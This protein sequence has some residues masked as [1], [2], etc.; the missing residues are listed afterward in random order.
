MDPEGVGGAAALAPSDRLSDDR[1][2]TALL[3]D[4]SGA[5]GAGTAAAADAGG[6]A[7]TAAAY[8]TGGAA[9]AA[10]VAAGTG[11]TAKSRISPAWPVWLATRRPSRPSHTRRQPSAVA[12]ATSVEPGIHD[13]C[14]AAAGAGHAE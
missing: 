6:A 8:A 11:T 7:A 13:T 1:S 12:T 2:S 14:G 9:A 4:G 3:A 10:A 5:S